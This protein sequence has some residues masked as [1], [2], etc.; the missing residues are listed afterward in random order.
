MLQIKGN[1]N[2]RNEAFNDEVVG[3]LLVEALNME[4]LE[5]DNSG[6]DDRLTSRQ[7][8][9]TLSDGTY[10]YQVS[11]CVNR[12]PVSSGKGGEGFALSRG[13]V[14]QNEI[15]LN[16]LTT[17][18]KTRKLTDSEQRQIAALNTLLGKAPAKAPEAPAKVEGEGEAVSK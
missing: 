7:H 18:A 1:A 3:N 8:F 6:K 2:P 9:I 4:G 17:I 15:A 10:S 12:R 11:F 14:R 5:P 16:S 13:A